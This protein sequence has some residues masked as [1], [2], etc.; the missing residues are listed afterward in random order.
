MLDSERIFKI[1]QKGHVG[2]FSKFRLPKQFFAF[3]EFCMKKEIA[4]YLQN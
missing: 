2:Q 1:G 3:K 4:Q